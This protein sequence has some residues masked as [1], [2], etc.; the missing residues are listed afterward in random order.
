MNINAAVLREPNT[1]FE[2]QT[3]QLDPPKKGEVLVN[4]AAS[5]VC[6][7]DWH[8]VTGATKHPMPVVA[9]HEGAGIV[10][11]VG[12]GVHTVKP[13]DHVILNWAP[14][15]GV[16]FYCQHGQPNLCGT[17][18][19]PIWAGTLLDGTPRLNSGGDPVYHFCGLATFADKAV[20]PQESCVPISKEVPLKA[21]ALVGC[22]VATGVGAVLYTAEVRPGE[23]VAVYG[24]GGVGLNII[25]AAALSGAGSIIAVDTNPAKMEM[26]KAFGASHTL[27]ANQKNW[28]QIHELTSGRGADVV[29]EAVG[30]PALQEEALR[31]T[32]PGGTLVLVGLSSVKEPTNLSGAFITRQEKTVKGSY[33]GSVSIRRDFPLFL[34]WYRAGRLKLDEL[35][36]QEYPLEEI[37]EA[38][39]AMLGGEVARGVVVF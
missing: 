10:E 11:E 20:V 2:I 30:T 21:A 38:Y 1:P 34:D 29:F 22:A 12:P 6:H 35:I 9:G 8:L 33:Y 18:L 31:A 16:C 39:D 3:I 7:S 15:C 27:I 28:K 26:A 24:C 19:R 32:R 36:T 4:I 14:D 25:Q 5:G 23:S 13:G 17:F 37:N